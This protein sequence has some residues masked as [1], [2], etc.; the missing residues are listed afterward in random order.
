MRA[1]L[2]QIA[3]SGLFILRQEG[4]LPA[5]RYG[6]Q[7]LRAFWHGFVA[8]YIVRNR[9]L[10][11]TLRPFSYDE[12]I[13]TYEPDAK[14]LARRR[15]QNN[16]VTH[17][18]ISFITP[19]YNPAPT[20]LRDTIESV[21]AQTYP[22]WELCL[23][24]GGSTEPGVR[25]VLRAYEQR[26][27]RIKVRLLDENRGIAGNMNVGL[28]LATGEY[29]ALLDHD[30]LVAPHL[31]DTVARRL[32]AEPHLD[33]VYFDED[34]V[35]EDGKTRLQPWF[36]PE[37]TPDLLFSTNLLMHSVLRRTLVVELGGF[38]STMDGA[39]DWD[40]AFRIAHTTDRIAHIPQVLYH[41]RQ[42]PGSAAR[43]AGAKPW[44]FDAQLNCVRAQ[45]ARLHV[46]GADA[47]FAALGSVRVRWPVSGALVSIIIPTKNHRELLEP[48]LAT[49]LAK[50]RYP[51][52]EIIL[53]DN[54]S[55]DAD[56]LAYYDE[57]AQDTRSRVRVVPFDEPFNYS[58]ANNLGASHAKGDLLLFLNNDTEIVHEDW[59]DELVGWV[60]R[61]EVGVVGAKLLRPDGT[62][63]HA[64]MIMGLMGHGSHIFDGGQDHQYTYFGSTDWVREY[65]AVTGACLMTTRAVFDAVGDFDEVYTIGFSD[66]EFCLRVSESGQR[67]IFTPFARLLHKEGGSRG[68]Y[69]PPADI[70]R[71]TYQMLPKILPGDPFFNPNLSYQHRL[72]ALARPNSEKRGERLL[73][74]L[75][76]YGLATY[77]STPALDDWAETA[78]LP[79]DWPAL[80]Q[81]P[82]KPIPRHEAHPP[83]EA[84][85]K[86]RVLLFTHDLSLSGAPLVMCMFGRRLQARGHAVAVVSPLDGPLRELYAQAGVKVAVEPR[87]L[88]DVRAAARHI[89][90]D[91]DVVMANTILS[92]RVIHTARAFGRRS[93]WWLHESGYGRALVRENEHVALALNVADT[94]LFPAQATARLY[95]PWLKR[96]N[97]LVQPYGLDR[98]MLDA[99]RLVSAAAPVAESAR[100]GA[101]QDGVT[102]TGATQAGATQE[103]AAQ[104]N[105]IA[106]HARTGQSPQQATA[107]EKQPAGIQAGMQPDVPLAASGM[108]PPRDKTPVASPVQSNAD[109]A[110]T[111]MPNRTRQA[112][113]AAGGEANSLPHAKVNILHVGSV[114]PRKG[115]DTLVEAL[116]FMPPELRPRYEVFFLGRVLD[117]VFWHQVMSKAAAQP[118]L[119]FLGE[120]P[121][122]A[123]M[124]H[125]RAADIF[126]LS[127]RD[128]VLPVTVLEAMYHGRAIVATD[129]GGVR[130]MI[131]HGETGFVVDAEDSAS[132][133]QYIAVLLQ[134][135]DLRARFG[136][137]ARSDFM[138]R[139]QL[140]HFESRLTDLMDE[141]SRKPWR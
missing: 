61:P 44:A 69:L 118:N 48:C 22:A 39:Q 70:V 51:N 133:A 108:L 71:A 66:I 28:E 8:F 90:Q 100:D 81:L 110:P 41:W 35:A 24:D 132:M 86:P 2:P 57:L 123:A 138:E 10:L 134:D 130:E 15:V 21:L 77:I 119:H 32:Q 23:V 46:Q 106:R 91:W 31:L 87:V 82:A 67:V 122:D 12:W 43:D 99:E 19:V 59:L 74:I 26:D 137:E 9:A 73:S 115:Q 17:P 111:A 5:L 60:E 94:V 47:E 139:Y 37:F 20:V 80:L 96:D 34:K 89:G 40:L 50:T 128:E 135:A 84:T 53:V 25:E 105:H 68:F 85:H 136:K 78:S 112:S 95:A 98:A 117:P 114:E 42:V 56:V 131:R 104:R 92:W 83:N 54:Q 127:S 1:Q 3:R 14:T 109:G 7:T 52:Y 62:I 107:F 79:A 49:L 72:P 33:V 141:L 116:Q 124:A 126:V 30:D 6:I 103:G 55:T 38:D 75:R 27:S 11:A 64:G 29:I 4:V 65:Q 113:F 88:E 13:K 140:A 101:D 76:D 16:G 58:R 36:K 45:L 121:H 120:T 93:I 18:R 125:L 63:Q 129:V 102:L 97:H